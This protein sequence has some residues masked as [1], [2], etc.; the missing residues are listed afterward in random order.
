MIQL[1]RFHMTALVLALAS[2]AVSA[3]EPPWSGISMELA[4]DLP[5]VE[6]VTA[7][8]GIR[9]VDMP[10]GS[11]ARKCGVLPGDIIVG[12]DGHDWEAGVKDPSGAY[13]A[14]VTARKAGDTLSLRIVRDL[15]EITRDGKPAEKETWAL[16]D[17]LRKQPPGTPVT[18]TGVR[19]VVLVEVKVVLEARPVPKGKT[20]PAK[21]DFAPGEVPEE[22]LAAA[23]I[24]EK[25][26]EEPC[27]DLRRRL[28]ALHDTADVFRMQR[29][30][31]IHRE[32]FHLRLLGSAAFDRL[33]DDPLAEAA[34]W[35]DASLPVVEPL[36]TGLA[37]EDHLTQ[38]IAVLKE[39]KKLRD[40]AFGGLSA[41]DVAFLDANVDS[42]ATQFTVHIYLESDE[43]K[44][45]YAR[46]LKVLD[47]A[48][49]VDY[50]KLFAAARVLWRVRRP[51]YLKD[52]EAAVRA[53]WE[54]K[55]K[56][57][58]DFVTRDTEAGKLIVSG[59]GR[60]W[61]RDDAAILLDLGGNDV[62][63]QNAGAGRGG[64]A[65]QIDFAGDDAYEATQPWTQGAGRL[66]VGC[67]IDVEGNDRY[68]AIRQAQGCALLGASLCSDLGGDDAYRAEEYAQGTAL[69]GIAI[70]EDAAGNDQ[71]EGRLLC[72]GVGMPGGTGVLFD[73]SGDDHYYAKGKSPTNYGDAGIFDAW[74]QG[75]G[76]GFRQLQSGGVGFLLDLSGDD[77]YEAANFSQGGGYY[78]GVGLFSD[79][80]G[81]DRYTGSRY[82]QGFCAHQAAGFFE[83]RDGSDIYDTRHGVA[84]GLAWDLSVTCFVDHGGDDTYYGWGG[85]SQAASAHNS[86]CIFL[87][88]GGKD[89]YVLAAQAAAG[90]NDY[91]GGTSLSLFVDW[92]G[93]ADDYLGGDRNNSILSKP[94]H[95]FACD[96]AG[97]IEEALKEGAFRKL[98]K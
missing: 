13:R 60:T 86:V 68:C 24:A 30:A 56:P 84:Q 88:P 89:R 11:P 58:G 55:G 7:T 2:I 67:M 75:C 15:I 80:S 50:P 73:A 22:Q 90:G 20:I 29:I 78:F 38:L 42:L 71:Y 51:A 83:D 39:A 49:R 94:E 53:E 59:A 28:A 62:Y 10:D 66:G 70:L 37:F 26:L 77:I 54:A 97:V 95:G 87:D 8:S 91:H 23:L 36:K 65:L 34:A 61:H 35:L 18:L 32:P 44:A 79:F 25:K 43:D 72:Q 14:A 3:G 27:A 92:G 33:E 52:L 46:H 40:E 76:V 9:V 17:W 69:W 12:I 31:Y 4:T 96:L 63:T 98:M 21:L 6:G 57:D 81:H 85:F 45:R 64:A 41:E 1:A 82:N 5:K 74:S 16:E 47:L 19:R 93:D 48:T